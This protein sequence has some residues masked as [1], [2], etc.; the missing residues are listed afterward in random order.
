[1][2][3]QQ[4]NSLLAAAIFAGLLSLPMT[5]MT[6]SGAEIQGGLGE[7]FG[8]AFGGMTINV[9]GLNGHVTLLVKTPIWFIVLV[10]VSAS[11][12][13]LMKGTNAVSVPASLEWGAA[14]IS[15][16]WVSIAILIAIFSGQSTLAIG[17]LLG[18]FSAGTPLAT[19]I[20]STDTKGDTPD[21]RN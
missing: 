21:V 14:G 13:Q 4:K 10:A 15:V 9:T 5:W 20:L 2:K 12:L 6:I 17:A 1:M 19:L 8:S 18:L 3:Q 11:G 7:L 16:A